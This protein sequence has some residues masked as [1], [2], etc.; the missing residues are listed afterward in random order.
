MLIFAEVLEKLWALI[1]S[2]LATKSF[3]HFSLELIAM[4]ILLEFAEPIF[5]LSLEVESCFN[6]LFRFIVP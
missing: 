5:Y 4:T 1:F 3:I 2:D 6:T